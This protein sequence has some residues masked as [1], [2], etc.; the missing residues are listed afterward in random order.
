MCGISLDIFV[1]EGLSDKIAWS[2][3]SV[4]HVPPLY[5][6]SSSFFTYIYHFINIFI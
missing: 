2:A 1:L 3:T 6:L 5:L 4:S